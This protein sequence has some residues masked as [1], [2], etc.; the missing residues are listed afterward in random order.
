VN[1]ARLVKV[2]ESVLPSGTCEHIFL[3]A[4]S[5]ET[6]KITTDYALRF[7]A[8][9]GPNARVISFYESFRTSRSVDTRIQHW[10][11]AFSADDE[12]RLHEEAVRR[13]DR[14]ADGL[15]DDLAA[16]FSAHRSELLYHASQAAVAV[17][18]L[19]KHRGPLCFVWAGAG[20]LGPV[21]SIK[22][23]RE[24]GLPKEA[25]RRNFP[26]PPASPPHNLDW[27]KKPKSLLPK[28][29]QKVIL[30]G[31]EDGGNLVRLDPTLNICRELTRRGCRF[32]V[33]TSSPVVDA[34][35][36][37]AG[38]PVRSIG[39]RSLNSEESAS[40][41]QCIRQNLSWLENDS[42]ADAADRLLLW[43]LESY[44]VG[45]ARDVLVLNEELEKI[46]RE[47][48]VAVLLTLGTCN[49]L[50]DVLGRR[51]Q[52]DGVK[53][54]TY[55]PILQRPSIDI[56]SSTHKV[57]FRPADSY[58]V[59]GGHLQ[60]KLVEL[61]IPKAAIEVVGSTTFD[62]S[63]G[64]DRERDREYTRTEILKNWSAGDKLVVVGTECSPR[65]F[66]EI[67]P[68]VRFLTGLDGVHTVIKVHP[69]DPLEMYENYAASLN[70]GDKLEVVKSCD[71]TALIHAAE[72]LTCIFSNLIVTAAVLGT[73]TLVV[74]FAY[75][76]APLDFV[77]HGLCLGCFERDKLG[78]MLSDLLQPST[79]R[80][81]AEAMLQSNIHCFNGLNDGRS[82]ARVADACGRAIEACARQRSKAWMVRR[83]LAQV[84][85]LAKR[86]VTHV[87]AM[88]RRNLARSPG[89]VRAVRLVRQRL[90]GSARPKATA[91]DTAGPDA[92]RSAGLSGRDRC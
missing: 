17:A 44:L 57:F 89:L 42:R 76:R 71:V 48:D 81:T 65:P 10:R 52:P 32:L 23:Q 73:P 7:L 59:Y 84:P 79:L 60:A 6:L 2:E 92:A 78:Q 74:D 38:F 46:D 83:K 22:V 90:R 16:I 56:V 54:L 34:A 14:L 9:Y 28:G 41:Y 26:A 49:P 51:Y 5:E 3:S 24:H 72:L 19:Q 63:L 61:R 25:F 80:S 12:A 62:K 39:S 70:V 31:V 58:L 66:E 27:H 20:T 18:L 11:D 55:L 68:I 47:H 69:S 86:R 40:I 77:A 1:F 45:A 88:V 67:D 53:W 36:L 33:V 82:A 64:R 75:K 50:V 30:I 91:I 43:R 21:A 87:F 85:A 8:G 37:E 29:R 15:T 4:Y 35:M 13:L